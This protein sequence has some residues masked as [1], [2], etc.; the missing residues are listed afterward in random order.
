MLSSYLTA[1]IPHLLPHYP[2]ASSQLKI[3][4]TKISSPN[5]PLNVLINKP[6]R[7]MSS[8]PRQVTQWATQMT[9]QYEGLIGFPEGQ[10]EL[11]NSTG[12]YR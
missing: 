4:V 6:P 7:Y 1:R 5:L 8:H 12:L 3:N 2:F 11:S 9:A 10:E